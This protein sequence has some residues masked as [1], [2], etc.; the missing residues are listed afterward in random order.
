MELIKDD[1][2]K[3]VSRHQQDLVMTLHKVCSVHRGMLSISGEIFNTLGDIISTLGDILSTSKRYHDSY[4]VCMC[5][6]G[7]GGGRVKG[8]IMSTWGCSLHGRD[9][10]SALGD[11]MSTSGDIMSTSRGYHD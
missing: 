5:V 10:M 6:C 11:I 7:R 8:Y 4:H 3:Q 2:P 9:I 1:D